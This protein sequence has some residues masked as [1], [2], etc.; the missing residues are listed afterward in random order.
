ME[1]KKLLASLLAGTAALSMAACSG[2]G[3][4]GSGDSG[5]GDTGSDEKKTVTMTVS[6]PSEDQTSSDDP[7]SGWLQA[8]CEAFAAEH[9]DWDITFNYK[10]IPEGSAGDELAKDPEAGPDVYLFASDQTGRLIEKNAISRFGGTA[11]D[12]INNENDPSMVSTVTYNDGVYGVP[13]TSNTW[14]M[15]YNKDIFTPEDVTNLDTML[16]KGP[17][18]FP[19]DNFWYSASFFY[20]AGCTIYGADGNDVSAGVDFDNENGLAALNYLIDLVNNPNFTNDEVGTGVGL[21]KLRDGSVG[22]VF[23]GSWD[24]ENL[25]SDMGDKL[26]LAG[27]P[28][29][30]LNGTATPLRAYLT[31]K[32]VG[33]N[34]NSKDLEVANALA[35]YLGGES[36]QKA[37]WEQRSVVPCNTKLLEDESIKSSD[38]VTAQNDTVA[39]AVPQP[40]VSQMANIFTFGENFGKSIVSGEVN[41]DNAQEK[42][43]D[44]V[45]QMNN[46]TPESE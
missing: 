13:F 3:D 44:W 21:S 31:S 7:N 2:S 26:G 24:Y 17:V 36:A 15:F 16:E 14:F 29:F 42:L 9:P 41:H 11:L 6:G 30:N 35:L 23:S 39:N 28:A 19:L 32:A 40:S 18:S 34:P 5:S 20:G 22:N 12:T 1:M 27:A 8:Q 46:I 45:T 4:S 33:V 43:T 10:T 37:H 38:L 25:A